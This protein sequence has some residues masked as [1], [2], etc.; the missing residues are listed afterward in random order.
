MYVPAELCLPGQRSRGAIALRVILDSGAHFT[1]L[2]LPIVEMMERTFRGVQMRVPFS[3]GARHAVT[4]SG[5]NVSVTERT[6]PLQLALVTAWGPAPLP[7]IYLVCDHAG[8]GWSSSSGVADPE[9]SWDR[10]V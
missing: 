1:S 10:S 3:L 8:V 2:S 5:Q 4:A 7:P 6:I 9:G